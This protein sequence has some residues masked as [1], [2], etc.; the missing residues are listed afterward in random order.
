MDIAELRAD[1]K[2]RAEAVAKRLNEV[3]EMERRL[4]AEK[5]QLI[6]ESLQLNGEAR[7]L[8]RL[9]DDGE[10]PKDG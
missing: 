7:L 1:H 9:S 5:Q 3:L 10:K 6:N 4:A 8:A 2:Q